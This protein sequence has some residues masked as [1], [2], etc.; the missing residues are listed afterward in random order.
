MR[1]L[2]SILLLVCLACAV[3]CKCVLGQEGFPPDESLKDQAADL[4]PVPKTKLYCL[5]PKQPWYLHWINEFGRWIDDLRNQGGSISRTV[6]KHPLI[7]FTIANLGVILLAAALAA[8]HVCR[9][10]PNRDS[11]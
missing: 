7:L 6:E 9:G 8:L 11:D 3:H 1:S 5:S 10:R 2:P 4:H